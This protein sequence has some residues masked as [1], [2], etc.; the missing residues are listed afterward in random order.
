M[1]EKI[2]FP[3]SAYFAGRPSDSTMNSLDLCREFHNACNIPILMLSNDDNIVD[4]VLSL[5]IGCDDFMTKDFDSRELI[6][7]I[8][9]IV[10]RSHS[11]IP[12]FSTLSGTSPSADSDSSAKCI[13]FPGLVINLT[14]YSVSYRGATI[15]MPPREL[16]LLYFLASSPNQVF[17]REQLLDHVWGYE[18]VGDTRTVDVHIKRLRAKLPGKNSWSN[19]YRMGSRLQISDKTRKKRIMFLLVWMIPVQT[20]KLTI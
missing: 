19:R 14:N 5:E 17:T 18:Y 1:Q 4:K 20:M 2:C 8:R 9:A 10:R 7:R 6:A 12:D 13:T 11:N 16:E 3:F 15:E